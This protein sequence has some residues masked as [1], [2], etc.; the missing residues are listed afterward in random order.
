MLL[1]TLGLHCHTY[2]RII[3]MNRFQQ[4]RFLFVAEGIAGAREF[5]THCSHNITCRGMADTFPLVRMH[6]QEPG[7]LLVEI[8]AGI[9]NRTSGLDSA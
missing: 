1:D 2:Y 4:D 8:L 3:E 7:R 9:V 5:E 6:L